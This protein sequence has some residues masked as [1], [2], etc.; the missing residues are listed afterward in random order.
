LELGYLSAPEI[1]EGVSVVEDAKALPPAP[2]APAPTETAPDTQPDS[3]NAS[4]L[5]A[6]CDMIVRRALE[7]AGSRLRSA[8][9]KGQPGGAASVACTDPTALHTIYDATAYANFSSLL[10]GAWLLVPEIADRYGV[11][12]DDLILTLETYTRALL[13]AKQEHRYDRLAS[14]LPAS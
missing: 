6:S 4:A 1:A 7:R 13:A 3:V 5:V 2:T 12:S 14:A 8:A 11:N 9:G 10:E